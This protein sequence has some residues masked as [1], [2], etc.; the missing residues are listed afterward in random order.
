AIPATD[1]LCYTT[2]VGA[3]SG[4]ISWN[5]SC[6]SKN[7]RR[8]ALW[9]CRRHA[10]RHARAAADLVP[11]RAQCARSGP[12]A[13]RCRTGPQQRSWPRHPREAIRRARTAEERAPPGHAD[14]RGDGRDA[15]H[16]RYPAW[17]PR[18]GRG[19]APAHP[20]QHRVRH[21][22]ALRRHGEGCL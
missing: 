10:A 22:L 6:R 5:I 15:G 19:R 13:G 8:A 20:R 7:R 16:R 3:N 17:Y 9:A 2:T 12:R 21:S 4:A 18:L 1:V 11:G 14:A